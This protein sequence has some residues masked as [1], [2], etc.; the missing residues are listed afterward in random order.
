MKQRLMLVLWSSLL[1]SMGSFAQN[2]TSNL[3]NCSWLH[4]CETQLIV[5]NETLDSVVYEVSYFNEITFDELMSEFSLAPQTT[6]TLYFEIFRPEIFTVNYQGKQND[7]YLIPNRHLIF[8]LAD[9]LVVGGEHAT[10]YESLLLIGDHQLEK[11]AFL[12]AIENIE[13]EALRQ[14]LVQA[15]EN[16]SLYLKYQQ[17]GYAIYRGDL[18]ARVSR[19]DSILAVQNLY[20]IASGFDDAYHSLVLSFKSSY[21]YNFDADTIDQKYAKFYRN[22][23]LFDRLKS[24]ENSQMRSEFTAMYLEKIIRKGKHFN[25]KEQLINDVITTLPIAY[26]EKINALQKEYQYKGRF[27]KVKLDEI[28]TTHLTF[29]DQTKKPIH[30]GVGKYKLL[31]FWFAGCAPCKKQIP[32]EK[33]LLSKN[34]HLQ[35]INLCYHADPLAWNSYIEKYNNGGTHYYLQEEHYEQFKRVFQLS[36]AP[37]YVLLDKHNQVVCWEC[38]NPSDGLIEELIQEE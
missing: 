12:L 7:F 31:K 4:P 24:I 6:D 19:Q 25:K 11:E 13:V 10:L 33:E 2:E 34:E 3:P 38:S 26:V 28:F 8:H 36:Y 23:R 32:F 18:S 5:S 20:P 37:R 22:K 17:K 1:C 29:E 21:E 9:D 35:V 16:K 27:D 15:R 14:L 30:L